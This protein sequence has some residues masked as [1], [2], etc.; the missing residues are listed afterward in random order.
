MNVEVNQPCTSTHLIPVLFCH[1]YMHG[2]Y[3]ITVH[4]VAVDMFTFVTV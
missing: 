3:N 4:I 2:Y 1:I